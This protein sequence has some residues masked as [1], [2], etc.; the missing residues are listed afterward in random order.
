MINQQT[1]I[2][3]HKPIFSCPCSIQECLTHVWPRNIGQLLLV[4][5]THSLAS[6]ELFFGRVLPLVLSSPGSFW[7]TRN[8]NSATTSAPSFAQWRPS[9][10]HRWGVEGFLVGLCF[11][12]SATLQL[13]SGLLF[14]CPMEPCSSGLSLDP[15]ASHQE[16]NHGGKRLFLQ[17]EPGGFSRILAGDAARCIAKLF[18]NLHHQ[19]KQNTRNPNESTSYNSLE[20]VAI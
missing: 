4:T 17:N 2:F 12:G 14:Y 8:R 18:R 7:Q 1:T 5:K 20:G 9:S 3:A 6:L 11:V 15:A 16:G 19:C 13:F 10:P